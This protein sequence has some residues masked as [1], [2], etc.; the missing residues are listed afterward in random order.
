LVITA[1]S[2]TSRPADPPYPLG[3]GVGRGGAL[4]FAG[5]SGAEP[6]PAP[7]DRWEIRIAPYVGLPLMDG[8]ATVAGTTADVDTTI[9]DVFET[10]HFVVAL[11][12]ET[13]VWYRGR[14]GLLF[15]G[16]A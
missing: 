6:P 9:S 2:R 5:A 14:W 16:R 8:H 15:N 3:V 12:G 7:E 13:E 1:G 4:L 11:S 10:S